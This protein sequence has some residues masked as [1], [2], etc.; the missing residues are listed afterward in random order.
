MKPPGK[1]DGGK[2]LADDH[3]FPSMADALHIDIGRDP[4]KDP[5]RT[6]QK[7]PVPEVIRQKGIQKYTEL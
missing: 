7:Y 6:R 1:P 4:E 2:E 3:D 5:E